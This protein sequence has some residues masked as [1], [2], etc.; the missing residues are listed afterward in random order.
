MI[1]EYQ[2]N[3]IVSESPQ[4]GPALLAEMDAVLAENATLIE[5]LKAREQFV[6]DH[7]KC[8]A[9]RASSDEV[10]ALRDGIARAI[11]ELR[12]IREKLAPKGAGGQLMPTPWPVEEY[13]YA[14]LSDLPPTPESAPCEGIKN[15][16][17]CS[18]CVRDG[19]ECAPHAVAEHGN[20]L[21]HQEDTKVA[22]SKESREHCAVCD[23]GPCDHFKNLPPAPSV[24]EKP[25]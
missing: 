25:I 15:G 13:L 8:D 4:H 18:P 24:G 11:Q 20:D 6:L 5:R 9:L 14:L 19:K 23:P 12:R 3:R 22:E 7:E 21:V 16:L 10:K 2:R 17:R 1:N